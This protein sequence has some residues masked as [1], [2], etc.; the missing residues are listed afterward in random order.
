MTYGKLLLRYLNEDI[1]VILG[2]LSQT[3]IL[4]LSH[5]VAISHFTTQDG[6]TALRTASFNGHHKVVELLLGAG[7]NPDL[8]DKVRTQQDSGVQS[9]LSNVNGT[10]SC[11]PRSS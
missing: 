2:V 3:I 7:A 10:S 11:E 9:N 4:K 8:Q 6:Y 5:V 1:N